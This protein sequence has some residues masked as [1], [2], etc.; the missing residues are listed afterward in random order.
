M[1]TPNLIPY[2]ISSAYPDY[3][4]PSLSEDFGIINET[5]I[6]TFFIEQVSQF[7]LDRF[8]IDQI[9]ELEDISTFWESYYDDYYMDNAPWR[10]MIFIEGE[11]RCVNPPNELIFHYIQGVKT[12]EINKEETSEED[13]EADFNWEHTPEEKIV[14]EKM[15]EFLEKEVVSESDLHEMSI[16]NQHEQL[17]FVFNKLATTQLT[18][19]KYKEYRELLNGFCNLVLRYVEYD[20]KKTTDE[21]QVIHDQKNADRLSYLTAMYANIMVYKSIYS[22]SYN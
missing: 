16:M 19:E 15:K 9:N 13:Y 6:G 18:N 11:W 14:Q 8:D 7:I 21:L 4:R 12:G 10:A 20:M 5:Q 3:K 2:V 1:T 22:A 17:L